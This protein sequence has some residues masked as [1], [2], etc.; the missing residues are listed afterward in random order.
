MHAF[1]DEVSYTRI[2][3]PAPAGDELAMPAPRRPAPAGLAPAAGRG[4]GIQLTGR[5]TKLG[6]HEENNVVL[7]GPTVSARHATVRSSRSA[8]WSRTRAA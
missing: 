1:D 2:I 6:R 7:A 4:A 3:D 8:S 5:M